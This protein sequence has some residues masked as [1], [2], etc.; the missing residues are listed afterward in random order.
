[1]LHAPS[2][3]LREA[4]ERGDIEIVQAAKALFAPDTDASASENIEST[5]IKSLLK[6]N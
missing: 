4:A 5:A 1:L 3:R 6:E 2:Q